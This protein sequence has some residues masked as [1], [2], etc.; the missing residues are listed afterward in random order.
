MNAPCGMLLEASHVC[1]ALVELRPYASMHSGE[2]A[3]ADDISH[4]RWSRSYR[5]WKAKRAV[6]RNPAAACATR[7]RSGADGL[8]RLQ[9]A[10]SMPVAFWPAGDVTN[11]LRGVNISVSK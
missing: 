8:C 6:R 2:R 7:Q 10:L 9:L 11:A 4:V 3:Q 5:D 1:I